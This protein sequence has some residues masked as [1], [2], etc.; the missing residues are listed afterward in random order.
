MYHSCLG[1][2]NNREFKIYEGDGRSKTSPQN[3]TWLY[4][5]S[6]TI[7]QTR[8]RPTIWVKYPKNKLV[9]AVSELKQR[10][11]DSQLHAYVVVKTSNLV[12]S[13]RRYAEDRKHTC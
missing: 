10:G 6:F 1:I 9:R 2:L 3:I 4:H 7:I 5:K 8:S 13:R 12:I 11:K